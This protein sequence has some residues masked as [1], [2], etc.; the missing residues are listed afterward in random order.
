MAE[1]ESGPFRTV[2]ERFFTRPQALVKLALP[3]KKRDGPL[4]KLGISMLK[5][6]SD[7]EISRLRK[8]I[9]EMTTPQQDR[10]YDFN[11][12][13]VQKRSWSVVP[14]EDSG[15]F[16]EEEISRI[17]PALFSAGCGSCF[18]VGAPEMPAEFASS[19]ELSASQDDFR[20]FNAEC[21]VLRVLLTNADLSWAIS[22]NEWF[23]LFACPPSLLEHMLGCSI[24]EARREFLA[25][26]GMVEQGGSEGLM[27]IAR[28]YS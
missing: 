7:F 4:R 23:K 20:A 15:H 17:V 10:G 2:R 19:Y 24:E 6:L 16:A 14:V 27:R 21:G 11:P 1:Y 28:Q 18:S 26:A 8:L 22:C 5:K 9:R 13:W 12:A 3:S 25:Y